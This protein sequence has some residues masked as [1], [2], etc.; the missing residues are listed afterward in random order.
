LTVLDCWMS[1]SALSLRYRSSKPAA[2]AESS[3]PGS[4]SCE[5]R[6]RRSGALGLVWRLGNEIRFGI[7]PPIYEDFHVENRDLGA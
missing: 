2:F 7:Y 6:S 5:H 3:H 1:L 4:L